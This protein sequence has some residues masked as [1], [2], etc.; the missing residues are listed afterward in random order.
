MDVL[1]RIPRLARRAAV[2][3]QRMVDKRAEHHDY[4]RLI[5][6]DLAEVT[7]WTWNRSPWAHSRSATR[8]LR[9][10]SAN[11]ETGPLVQAAQAAYARRPSSTRSRGVGGS[12]AMFSDCIWTRSQL[13]VADATG[14]WRSSAAGSPCTTHS[15]R[16]PPPGTPA[17]C[18]GYPSRTGPTCRP[19]YR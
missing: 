15:P 6:Q 1:D 12:P 11:P 2:L 13:P 10:M 18:S 8:R 19:G 16:S 4:V 7:G 9:D 14:G 3:R 17:R 5:G